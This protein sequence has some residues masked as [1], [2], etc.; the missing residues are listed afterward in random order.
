MFDQAN[1]LRK[2]VRST[3]QSTPALRPGPP[4]VVLTSGES[5][6]GVS[7]LAAQLAEEIAAVGKQVV[8]VDANLQ[9]PKLGELLGVDPKA[10]LIEALAGRKT[11]VEALESFADGGR[12]LAAGGGP[13]RAPDLQGNAVEETIQ[14]LQALH[15]KADVVLVD[16]GSGASPWAER[17]F[18]AASQLLIVTTTEKDAILAAYGMLKSLDRGRAAAKSRLVLNRVQDNALAERVADKFLSTC[19]YFLE[20]AE[21]PVSI[22]SQ[23]SAEDDRRFRDDASL[24]AAK[25]LRHAT[26]ELRR[27]SRNAAADDDQKKSARLEESSQPVAAR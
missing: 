5:G 22:V 24:L 15:T 8:L 26:A 18:R 11:V 14:Q 1:R 20:L 9:R 4:L 17:F 25:L 10:G 19:G 27:R 7:T 12:L 13:R 16:A 23:R 2:L 3:L 21:M 6:A